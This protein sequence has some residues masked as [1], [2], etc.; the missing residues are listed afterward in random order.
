VSD[1]VAWY[2]GDLHS[3]TRFSDGDLSPAELLAT[4][5]QEGLDFF[6]ITDH[7]SLAAYAE[8]GDTGDLLVLPGIEVTL[9]QGHFN[10]FGVSSRQEWTD[11]IC[12]GPHEVPLP[13]RFPS[14]SALMAHTAAT[15]LLNSLNHPFLEPWEWRDRAL[16]LRH[17]ACL[18][19]WNDPSWPDN[20][21]ANPR[22]VAFWTELLNAGYRL[23][24][25]GGSDYHRPKPRPGEEKPAERLGLPATYVQAG[26][27]T[28]AALLEALRRHRAYVSMGPRLTFQAQ[29]AGGRLWEIGDHLCDYAGL[30]TFTAVIANCLQ[31]ARLQLLQ[32]G[33]VAAEQWV[34]AEECSFEYQVTVRAGESAWFRLDLLH[35]D[36][37][38][39]WAVTNPIFAGPPRP[40]Q[41]VT[42]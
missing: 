19:I 26:S 34:T 31:P 28:V 13:A 27:L 14:T 15:G 6:A 11:E 37:N 29:T 22:A 7:N 30:V 40:L 32:N 23:T 18:E 2:R 17:L 41:P 5:G 24:A 8:F 16:E 36:S 9:P 1:K 4:A 38:L 21:L 42:W 35:A 20:A 39:I 3:H 12:T 10:V 33:R 25:V